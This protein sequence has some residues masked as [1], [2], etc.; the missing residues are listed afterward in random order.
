LP[1]WVQADLVLDPAAVSPGIIDA[2]PY[3]R[4][5]TIR[6]VN[7]VTAHIVE[8]ESFDVEIAGTKGIVTIFSDGESVEWRTTRDGGDGVIDARHILA[9][10]HEKNTDAVSATTESV[11]ALIAVVRGDQGRGQDVGLASRNLEVLFGMV[12]SHLE[13]GRRI[14]WPMERRNMKI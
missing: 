12:Y 8:A 10:V 11:R 5:A 1:E 14:R 7:G 2:D 4:T 9:R 13:E 3:I 6:Y